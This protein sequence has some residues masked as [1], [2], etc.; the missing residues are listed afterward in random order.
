MPGAWSPKPGPPIFPALLLSFSAVVFAQAPD[1][2]AV[3]DTFNAANAAYQQE[4]YATA[5]PL[6]EKVVAGAPDLPVAYLYL[7]SSYDH[8]FQVSR[9][10]QLSN[11]AF[12]TKAEQNYRT[13]A[14]KLIAQH[15]PDATTAATTCLAMLAALYGPDRLNNPGKAR[16]VTEELIRLDPASPA[17][18]LSLATLDEQAGAFANAEAALAKALAIRPDDARVLVQVASHY[19][20]MAGRGELTPVQRKDFAAKSLAADDRALAIDPGSADALTARAKLLQQEAKFETD[21]KK[22][23]QLNQQ[24]D[25]L[26]ARA[27]ALR[28]A[29]TP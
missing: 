11:D 10:G 21:K 28:D 12:L 4:Q 20:D 26:A 25:A 8:L 15:R 7:A 29:K 14:D 24:V 2:Q 17:Y 3:V 1:R 18:A 6:Y 16:A 23:Q 5:A 13:A 9:R 19:A 27:K 22:Q